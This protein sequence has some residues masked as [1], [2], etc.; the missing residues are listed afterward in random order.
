MAFKERKT[1]KR[2]PIDS[3]QRI[4]SEIR[5]DV[6]F[7]KD[8]NSEQNIL[9]LINRRLELTAVSEFENISVAVIQSKEQK[10]KIK[11]NE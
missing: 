1:P 2:F 4:S 7:Q 10:Y 9:Y 6:Y 3:N 5:S 11:K 8:P